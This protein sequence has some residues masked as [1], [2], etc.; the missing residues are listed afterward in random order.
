MDAIKLQPTGRVK[1]RY[2]ARYM[3]EETRD[4]QPDEL[5]ELRV[6]NRINV[7]VQYLL[8]I[9]EPIAAQ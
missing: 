9:Q 7:L 8:S 5:S 1:C 3:L 6:R 2:G 4:G